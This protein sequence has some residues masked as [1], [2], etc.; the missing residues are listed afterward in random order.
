MIESI[1]RK[2]S[3][4]YRVKITWLD[5]KEISQSF[6]RKSD[7]EMWKRFKLHER[8]QIRITGVE[9]QD[10]IIFGEFIKKWIT[11]KVES[12]LSPSSQAAYKSDL[13]IHILPVLND[14]T[15]RNL[16]LDHGNKIVMEMQRK[17]RSPKT[18]NGVMGLLQGILNDAIS[19]QYL[20]RNPLT[21]LAPLKQDSSVDTYWTASEIDQFLRATIREV[22][23]PLWV[24]ALNTGMRRGEL[25][26]LK[27]DR[28]SFQRQQIEVTRS[29]SRYG[30]RD[31][32]KGG[33][34]R[35]VPMNNAV[36]A[37]LW[38]LWQSQKSEFV[39]CEDGGS[40]VDA[41]HI[42]R[43]FHIAQRKAGFQCLIRFHDLRHTFAS[44]FMM[45][46][47]NIYDLQKILGHSTVAMTDR[48]AHLSPTHLG[49]SIQIVSFTGNQNSFNSN[50]NEKSE[51][52]EFLHKM[53]S[54][55]KFALISNT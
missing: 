42:Y 22:R 45:N 17:G 38:P 19:W 47:G 46:G 52:P 6:K 53:E 34:K 18:I 12:R 55:G 1:K 31:R 27:W 50:G 41:N 4:S 2:N 15:F 20:H 37:T 14:V 25:A 24:T 29:A 49:K 23:Y 3:F 13:K 7:A 30:L 43:D 51:P 33:R 9:V 35:I 54:N 8:D 26:G 28:V 39:F 40:A 11:D 36:N 44:H 16:R 5:G 21:S 10:S 32:T 48:Y